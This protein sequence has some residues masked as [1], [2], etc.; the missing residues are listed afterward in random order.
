VF[1]LSNVLIES[2]PAVLGLNSI[3]VLLHSLSIKL[4]GL[5]LHS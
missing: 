5:F 4:S 2:L 3:D 1:S